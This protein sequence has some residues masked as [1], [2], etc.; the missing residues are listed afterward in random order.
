MV[1]DQVHFCGLFKERRSFSVFGVVGSVTA[2]GLTVLEG[3]VSPTIV[4]CE[5]CASIFIFLLEARGINK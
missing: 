1:W 4:S 2:V 3:E 5:G